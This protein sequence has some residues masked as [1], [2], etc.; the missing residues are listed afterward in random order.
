MISASCGTSLTF[1]I[2]PLDL[3]D[4]YAIPLTF[5]YCVE[6]EENM[7]LHI[8]NSNKTVEKEIGFFI[9]QVIN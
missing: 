1:V 7:K 6:H 9:I 8:A 2:G 3:I 5:K 4:W